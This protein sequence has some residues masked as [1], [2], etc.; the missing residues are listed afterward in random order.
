[1]KLKAI[2]GKVSYLMIAGRYTVEAEMS[3][4]NAERMCAKGTTVSNRFPDYPI[5]VD[6]K[7]FFPGTSTKPKSNRRKPSCDT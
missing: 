7:F 5:C 4:E 1:M 3:L 2:D 6:D